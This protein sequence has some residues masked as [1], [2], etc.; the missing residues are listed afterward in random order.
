MPTTYFYIKG[1]EVVDDSADVALPHSLLLKN[2]FGE[3]CIATSNPS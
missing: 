1:A 3:C 2:R